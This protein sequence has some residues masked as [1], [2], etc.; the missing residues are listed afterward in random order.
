MQL[1]VVYINLSM[2]YFPSIFAQCT[3]QKMYTGKCG[4]TLLA[5]KVQN[6]TL[7]QS[8]LYFQKK[9]NFPSQNIIFKA[10]IRGGNQQ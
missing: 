9:K 7:K 10:C 4:F 2:K 8:F 1:T 3:F 5:I 6:V